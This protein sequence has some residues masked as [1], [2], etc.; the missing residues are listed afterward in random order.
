MLTTTHAAAGQVP[1]SRM[2]SPIPEYVSGQ[3]QKPI[4]LLEIN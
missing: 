3:L 2:P 1:V 4:R